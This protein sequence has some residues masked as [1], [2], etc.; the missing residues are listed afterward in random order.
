MKQRG[1]PAMKLYITRG[2][3]SLAGGLFLVPGLWA[4]GVLTWHNDLA[5][6]GQNLTE[7]LLSPANVSS[8]NFGLLANVTLDGPVDAQPLYLSTSRTL[9]VGT[10]NDTLYAL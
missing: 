10:E 9:Y 2:F 8:V 6:T 5:R 7:T 3:R 4:Q 1:R